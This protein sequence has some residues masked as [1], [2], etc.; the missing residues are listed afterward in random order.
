MNQK[1]TKLASNAASRMSTIRPSEAKSWDPVRSKLSE[2]VANNNV[3]ELNDFITKSK[4]PRDQLPVSELLLSAARGGHN[5]VFDYLL[6]VDGVDV[7]AREESTGYTALGLAAR[8][9]HSH[10]VQVLIDR[11]DVDIYLGMTT[12]SVYFRTQ[13]CTTE[14]HEHDS[15]FLL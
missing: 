8:Y 6:T 3:G 7:N 2:A 9:A 5:E 12:S 14:R 4:L 13:L 11:P 10:I 15:L 1:V